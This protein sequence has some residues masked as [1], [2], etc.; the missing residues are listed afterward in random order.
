MSA[1]NPNSNLSHLA[2]VKPAAPSHGRIA[3]QVPAFVVIGIIGF[4]VDAAVTYLG[5]KYAGLSPELA[6]PPGFIIATIVNFALNR[7][8][9]FRHARSRLASSSRV[10]CWSRRQGLRSTT[11]SIR[12]AFLL[13]PAPGLPSRPRFYR[14]SSPPAAGRRWASLSSAFGSSPFGREHCKSLAQSLLSHL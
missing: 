1:S 8:I 5:A 13:P 14:C 4:L 11:P 12:P 7:W 10:T 6:R 3:E 2:T 9:T